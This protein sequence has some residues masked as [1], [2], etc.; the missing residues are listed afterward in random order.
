M[1]PSA[2]RSRLF[3][4]STMLGASLLASCIE[5][6]DASDKKKATA[7]SAAGA[8]ANS[9][10]PATPVPPATARVGPDSATHI[11][12]GPAWTPEEAAA[13]QSDSAHSFTDFDTTTTPD[14]A[15][16]TSGAPSAAASRSSGTAPSVATPTPLLAKGALLLPVQGIEPSAL[17]DTYSERRGGGGRTHEAL[18][19]LAPRGTPVLSATGGR[20][21]KLFD[22]KAGGKMVYAA[23]S[24]ER[25]I[26]LYAHLDAYAPGLA[27]GQPLKRGQ[28]IGVVG[29]TGNAPPNVP[30]LHFAIARSND[31]KVWWKGEPVNPFP[32][33]AP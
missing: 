27:D 5:I 30:H 24:S 3:V 6:E 14:G 31:V 22:S 15:P 11:H 8:V 7:D 1:S 18:D 33:L 10:E 20:V 19:I 2:Q 17:H 29:T 12:G 32:L 13:M 16:A 26:L 4:F 23:D 21:L 9:A 28:V 25:F